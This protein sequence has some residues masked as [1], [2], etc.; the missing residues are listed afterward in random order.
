MVS[1]DTLLGALAKQLNTELTLENGVCALFDQ[2]NEV[3][4]I[5]IS[6]AGDVALLHCR[7]PM[8]PDPGIH[9]RLLRLNFDMGA[10]HG[11]WLAL[12]E[13][14]DVRLCAQASLESMG[15]TEF[16]HWVQGFVWQTREMPGLLRMGL[17]GPAKPMT[18]RPTMP[19]LSRGL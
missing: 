5:E 1:P 10:M 15:E 14:S 7:L 3:A 16:V 12:D 19:G 8:R 9:E 6:P 13:R 18:Q 2:D 4:I 17:G 11:C